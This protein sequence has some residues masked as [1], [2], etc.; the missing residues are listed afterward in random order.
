MTGVV[1]IPG[2][3]FGAEGEG[4]VR[5]ALVQDEARLLEAARRIGDWLRYIRMKIRD[6]GKNRRMRD[7]L[8]V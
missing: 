5:I 3:A 4:F 2:D 1:V 7:I 6:F 8:D